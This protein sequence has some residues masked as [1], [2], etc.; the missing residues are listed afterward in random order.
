MIK[1]IKTQPVLSFGRKQARPSF[2]LLDFR[3][4]KS[5][6]II[7]PFLQLKLS[8]ILARVW[9]IYLPA[10]SNTLPR[11]WSQIER[12]ILDFHPKKMFNLRLQTRTAW[13]HTT[14]TVLRVPPP[15]SSPPLK[16]SMNASRSMLTPKTTFYTKRTLWVANLDADSLL[17]K[18]WKTWSII[19]F[20]VIR[21][22]ALFTQFTT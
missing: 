7:G 17:G 2:G 1:T 5:T 11:V 20:W 13:E 22:Y 4:L 10:N 16:L 6:M 15:I 3:M 8:S 18:R 9:I 19:G 21:F 12:A 14:L